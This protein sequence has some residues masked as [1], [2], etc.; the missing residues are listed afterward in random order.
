MIVLQQVA[1]IILVIAEVIA[2]IAKRR[3]PEKGWWL[4]LIFYDKKPV[5]WDYSR[6][7]HGVFWVNN[8]S[9]NSYDSAWDFLRI[10]WL[11][12]M[13][14]ITAKPPQQYCGWCAVQLPMG[15]RSIATGSH[16][17]V[18]QQR[19]LREIKARM[20]KT[21]CFRGDFF[22]GRPFCYHCYHLCYH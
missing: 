22:S 3:N 1:E 15:S 7:V 6:S 9:V 17:C 21:E 4:I 16:F 20:R 19:V 12:M 13:R 18:K 11:L 2:V 8:I 10:E 14:W 5:F